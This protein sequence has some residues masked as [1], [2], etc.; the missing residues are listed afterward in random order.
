MADASSAW[1]IKAFF[2]RHGLT[3]ADRLGCNAAA[4]K[5]CPEEKIAPALTQGGCSY[6]ILAGDRHI[7]QFRPKRYRLDLNVADAAKNVYQRYAPRTTLLGELEL[8]GLLTYRME[9]LQGMSYKDYSVRGTEFMTGEA[10]KKHV[11]L[12]EDFALFLALSWHNR[13]GLPPKGKIGS[14]INTRLH[15]LSQD[16]PQRFRPHAQLALKHMDRL[17]C[18]PW[19]LNHGDIITSNI[20]L[21]PKTGHLTGLVDW[22]EAEVLPFGTCLYGL[23]ELLGTMTP[24]GFTYQNNSECLRTA[25]W[26]KLFAEIPELNGN[27]ELL[28]AIGMAREVGVLLWHGFAWDDGAIN[29]VV[30]EGRDAEEI[31]YLDA[32][33]PLR[34][35]SSKPTL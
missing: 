26:R 30:E 11:H 22:A 25:F 16:L 23:E 4:Q 17:N 35:I 10:S 21:D 28:E 2:S 12:I 32:F 6:T 19:V 13:G 20:I 5:L 24:T 29:R 31:R 15:Q 9:K 34:G 8:S 18:L 14:S 27:A 7:V 33:L 1:R 3:E